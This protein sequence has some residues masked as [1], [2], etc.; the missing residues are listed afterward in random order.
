VVGPCQPRGI[1]F[2]NAALRLSENTP[3]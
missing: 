3:D 1:K 2:V